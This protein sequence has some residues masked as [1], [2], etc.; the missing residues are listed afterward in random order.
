MQLAGAARRL[1][2]L[3][4]MH[5]LSSSLLLFSLMACTSSES[6]EPPL[7]KSDIARD[8]TPDATDADVDALVAGNTEF[9]AD[10]YRLASA[11]DGNLFMSPHSITTALA[12]T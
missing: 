3:C 9:A 7:L 10:L 8:T 11:E 2:T 1:K 6:N 4:G 12:M 5:R